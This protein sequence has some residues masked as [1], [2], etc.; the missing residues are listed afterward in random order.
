MSEDQGQLM[1]L[2]LFLRLEL[3]EMGL[4]ESQL[5]AWGRDGSLALGWETRLCGDHSG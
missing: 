5:C 4:E 3:K 2:H 1:G